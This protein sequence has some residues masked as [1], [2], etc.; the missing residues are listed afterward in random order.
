MLY[1]GFCFGSFLSNWT[2]EETRKDSISTKVHIF[3]QKD[4]AKRFALIWPKIMDEFFIPDRF[5]GK[6]EY[7]TF[8]QDDYSKLWNDCYSKRSG[9]SSASPANFYLSGYVPC[10]TITVT[11]LTAFT[12]TDWLVLHTLAVYAQRHT[13][14]LNNAF[15]WWMGSKKLRP[16]QWAWWL[17]HGKYGDQ[18]HAFW[19]NY[20]NTG[21]LMI[22]GL[23]QQE[24]KF[25]FKRSWDYAPWKLN[26]ERDIF[27]MVVSGH[28]RSMNPHFGRFFQNSADK[29]T[30]IPEIRKAKKRMQEEEVGGDYSK[31]CEARDEYKA[32]F[33]K[34]CVSQDEVWNRGKKCAI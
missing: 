16:F 32:I 20:P 15:R 7:G 19:G 11:D 13:E 23:L 30:K 3:A 34:Y 1:S 17:S 26:P 24:K 5:K 14:L 9:D 25:N 12:T 27:D 29:I 6:Y 28:R 22:P 2:F 8:T 10:F 33:N 21:W 31:Y 4:F 18:G